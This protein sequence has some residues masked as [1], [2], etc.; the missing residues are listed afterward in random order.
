MNSDSDIR[1][2]LVV[3]GD[4]VDSFTRILPNGQHLWAPSDIKSIISE[5]G[6]LV[7]TRDCAQPL[8]TIKQLTHLNGVAEQVIFLSDEV[9]PCA[10]SSTRLRTAI[11]EGRSIRYA[12]PDAVIQYIDKHGLYQ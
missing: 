1:L 2:K 4:V 8:D 5:F 6:L 3:G 10:V 12:T 11:K 7:I 9:C